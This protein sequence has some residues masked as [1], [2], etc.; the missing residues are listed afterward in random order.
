M[1][2]ATPVSEGKGAAHFTHFEQ[3]AV[4]D[5]EGREINKKELMTPPLIE[6]WLLPRWLQDHD[7]DIIISG[8]MSERAVSLFQKAGMKVITGAPALPPEDIVHRYLTDTLVT[9]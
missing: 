6:R 9:D 7:V 2:I 3:V 4:L 8:N 5:T 1:R